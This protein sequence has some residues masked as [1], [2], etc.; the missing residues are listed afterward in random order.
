MLSSFLGA[1]EKSKLL[2]RVRLFVTPMD[3]TDHGIL[4]AKILEYGQVEGLPNW[5]VSAIK[6]TL[7]INMPYF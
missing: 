4:Q 3:Y 6:L 7:Q 1:I 5:E 2:S